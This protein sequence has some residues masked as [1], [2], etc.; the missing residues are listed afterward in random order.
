M[1]EDDWLKRDALR[2][3]RYAQEDLS[4]AQALVNVANAPARNTCLH[5][6]QAAEKALKAVLIFLDLGVPRSYD[7]SG[8]ALVVPDDWDCKRRFTDLAELARWATWP[9]YP[10][11]QREADTRDAE[12]AI[13]QAGAT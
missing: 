13:A 7:L 8:I 11:D 2:W 9:R 12:R 6:Q 1:N 4:T 5:A 3:L 10:S